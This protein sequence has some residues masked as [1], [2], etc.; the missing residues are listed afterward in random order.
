MR[1]SH[2]RS[3]PNHSLFHSS[4]SITPSHDHASFS[5]NTLSSHPYTL[6]FAFP[7]SSAFIQMSAQSHFLKSF[8]S[9]VL[10]SFSP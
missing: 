5:A 7:L 6:Q 3:N 8:H 1:L 9:I 4:L 10:C 2:F